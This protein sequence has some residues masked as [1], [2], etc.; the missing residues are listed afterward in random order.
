MTIEYSLKDV[1]QT[2]APKQAPKFPSA[3]TTPPVKLESAPQPEKSKIS[4]I[5]GHLTEVFQRLKL[6]DIDVVRAENE[7][8]TLKVGWVRIRA[9]TRETSTGPDFRGLSVAAPDDLELR[10]IPFK[11][12]RT[13]GTS[14]NYDAIIKKTK[15]FLHA[16]RKY[17]PPPPKVSKRRKPL[18]EAAPRPSAGPIELKVEEAPFTHVSIIGDR[19]DNGSSNSVTNVPVT[20]TPTIQTEPNKGAPVIDLPLGISIMR[21]AEGLYVIRYDLLT[22]DASRV[23]KI[24]DALRAIS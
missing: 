8:F 11:G 5:E 14:F 20:P 24:L 19:G 9:I 16:T 21:D 10:V 22:R 6:A 4:V 23:Q 2:S 15:E 1:I 3:P 13:P 17:V 18:S 7:S 12:P